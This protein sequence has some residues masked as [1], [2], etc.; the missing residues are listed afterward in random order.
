[1]HHGTVLRATFALAILVGAVGLATASELPAREQTCIAVNARF[2]TADG[3]TLRGAVLGH[4][5]T[6][7]VFAHQLDGDRC[8]WLAFARELRAKGYRALVFDMRGY[9]SSTGLDGTYPDRDVTAAAK[10]LRRR[11]ATKIV[12]VG[13]SM[14]ATGVVVAAPAIKPT[15]AGVVELSAPTAFGG[16]SALDAARKL[17]SPAL[18][19]AGRDDAAFAPATRALYRAAATMDKRLVVAPSALHG[20]D[21]LSLPAVKK[22]VLAFVDRVG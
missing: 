21:L 7:V 9:G 4:G 22:A 10:E 2:R 17:R 20:V 1:M 12:L 11:G 8:Q 3:A 15:V 13:A 16:V 18:F 14:G 6:G 19:V 5:K